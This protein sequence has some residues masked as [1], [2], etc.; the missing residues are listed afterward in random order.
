M[1][2]GDKHFVFMLL[3]S[4]LKH[5]KLMKLTISEL[6]A[7]SKKYLVEHTNSSVAV[8]LWREKL[9]PRRKLLITNFTHEN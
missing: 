7:T 5:F 8:S 2:I 6:N 1:L 9:S 3:P 4:E